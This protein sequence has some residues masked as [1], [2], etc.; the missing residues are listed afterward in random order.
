M[1][2]WFSH[3][4][5]GFLLSASPFLW[6]SCLAG[7]IWRERKGATKR[8]QTAKIHIF[9]S[10]PRV[11]QNFWVVLFEIPWPLMLWMYKI[12][13]VPIYKNLYMILH[14]FYHISWM[15]YPQET[16]SIYS[17]MIFPRTILR[18]IN[19]PCKP[20][21]RCGKPTIF[22]HH[23][24]RG[25]PWVF[26][27]YICSTPGPLGERLA[28]GGPESGGNWGWNMGCYK[29]GYLFHIYIYV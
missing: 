22:D 20:L 11:D 10:G 17:T 12:S 8:F 2:R 1:Y 7:G 25:F 15:R 5:S 28:G 14:Y 9:L 26:H 18:R 24:P 19:Y 3:W 6:Q 4:M 27:I 21:H 16:L 29:L 13:L 23:F